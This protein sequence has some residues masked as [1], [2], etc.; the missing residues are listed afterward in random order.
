MASKLKSSLVRL[1][2]LN[3]DGIF[4]DPARIHAT[5]EILDY[6]RQPGPNTEEILDRVDTFKAAIGIKLNSRRLFF[7]EDVRTGMGTY[8][9]DEQEALYSALGQE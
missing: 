7:T 2:Q 3:Q 6:R 8:R 9:I 4:P 1:W 5:T